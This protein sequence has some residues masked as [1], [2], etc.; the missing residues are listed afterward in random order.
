LIILSSKNWSIR[1]T[2]FRCTA[3][4]IMKMSYDVR[5]MPQSADVASP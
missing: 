3:C 1:H 2:R 5:A 4:D